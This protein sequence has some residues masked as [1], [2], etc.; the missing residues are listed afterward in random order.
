MLKVA[1]ELGYLKVADVVGR[2][3]VSLGRQRDGLHA[4]SGRC[5]E[6]ERHVARRFGSGGFRRVND[7]TLLPDHEMTGISRV[8]VRIVLRTVGPVVAH[9]RHQRSSVGVD[10]DQGGGAGGSVFEKTCRL[11]HCA[12]LHVE[13]IRGNGSAATSEAQS[14][15]REQSSIA[16]HRDVGRATVV[17][18][19]KPHSRLAPYDARVVR[20]AGQMEHGRAGATGAQ[21]A[22]IQFEEPARLDG[23]GGLLDDN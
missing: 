8:V 18:K 15:G 7:K 17:A 16:R 10:G 21:G 20:T 22:A 9:R 4:L 5:R 19:I 14:L 2:R 13:N 1:Q 12:I 23:E 6:R 3:V 11:Y